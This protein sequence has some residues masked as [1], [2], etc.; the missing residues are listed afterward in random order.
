M[1]P[2]SQ[3]SCT[4][5]FNSLKTNVIYATFYSKSSQLMYIL[6]FCFRRLWLEKIPRVCLISFPSPFLSRRNWSTYVV[7]I[8]SFSLSCWC[9]SEL[10]KYTIIKYIFCASTKQH[11]S[12]RIHYSNF[13][14]KTSLRITP[15]RNLSF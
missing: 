6:E 10:L 1:Q 2:F 5:S 9:Y 12:S 14:N 4:Y 3:I 13:I 11:V 7:I 15:L 8:I